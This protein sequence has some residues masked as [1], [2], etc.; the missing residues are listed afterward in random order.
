MDNDITTAWVKVISYILW[1]D[2]QVHVREW[3][4]LHFLW[5]NLNEVECIELYDE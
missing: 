3:S 5:E 4:D 2:N 1:C